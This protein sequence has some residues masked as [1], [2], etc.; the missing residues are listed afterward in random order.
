MKKEKKADS[1]NEATDGEAK[2]TKAKSNKLGGLFRKPS[3]AVK[4]DKEEVAAAETEAKAD[5][6]EETP[7]VPAKDNE[8]T[9]AATEE[10]PKP[11]EEVTEEAKNVNVPASTP[12]QAAA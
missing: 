4:L 11:V 1:D 7:A 10:T 12:V 2:E 3:K 8:V 6:S 9:P 5:K